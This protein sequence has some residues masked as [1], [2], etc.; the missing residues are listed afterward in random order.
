[1]AILMAVAIPVFSA[2]LEKARVTVDKS[3]ARSAMSLA[4]ADY[5][6]NHADS[7]DT[8][9]YCFTKDDTD[10]NLTIATGWPKTSAGTAEGVEPTS[11][12]F[13]GKLQ[14]TVEP[15]GKVTSSWNLDAES[16][17]PTPGS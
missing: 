1:M 14:I 16:P 9:Y 5:L 7:A 6:L 10:Q 3:T 12:A 15:G 8:Y 4:E 13:S 17:T 2:Q 11:K